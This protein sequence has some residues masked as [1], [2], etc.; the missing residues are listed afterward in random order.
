MALTCHGVQYGHTTAHTL[1]KPV[2]NGTVNGNYVFFFVVVARSEN[3]VHDI[4]VIG[5][6]NKPLAGLIKPPYREYALRVIYI[7]NN[8][9]FNIKVSSALNAYR[10]IKGQVYIFILLLGNQP[11]VNPYLIIRANFGAHL[12]HCAVKGNAAFLNKAVGLAT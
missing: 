11:A 12:R 8:I 3:L 4:A 6:K 10:L 5:H 9:V 2:S 1:N 7:V